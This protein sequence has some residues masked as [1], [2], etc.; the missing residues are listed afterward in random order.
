[1]LA[2]NIPSSNDVAITDDKM[3]S[4]TPR[5]PCH[6]LLISSKIIRSDTKSFHRNFKFLYLSLIVVEE[7]L[8]NINVN[9]YLTQ[10]L[11]VFLLWVP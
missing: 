7:A 2:N 5:Q 10:T 9:T 11:F 4:R 6:Y 3:T 8:V 1:M